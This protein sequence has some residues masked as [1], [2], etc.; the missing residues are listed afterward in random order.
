MERVKIVSIRAIA[1]KNNLNLVTVWKKFD[2]YASIYGDDPNYV[3]RGPDGRRYP[4]E[5][6]VEFLERV[7]GRKIAL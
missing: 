6:F 5:R 3:I 7:L 2:W 4:T 1:R